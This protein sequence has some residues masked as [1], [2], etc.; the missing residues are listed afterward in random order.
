MMT[1]KTPDIL[2]LCGGRGVRLQPTTNL[3]PKALVP[4]KGTPIVDYVVNYFLDR[5]PEKITMC[6]GYKGE[7][8]RAHVAYTWPNADIEYSDAGDSAS[9]LRRLYQ[10]RTEIGDRCIVAYGDTFVNI[11][12]NLLMETHMSK[13]AEIT[14]VT[15][16][17]KSP[18]GL[19]EVDADLLVTQFREKPLQNFFIGMFVIE[20]RILDGLAPEQLDMDDGFGLVDLFQKTIARQKMSTYEHQGLN[21]TFNTHDERKIAEKEIINFYTIK[22]QKELTQ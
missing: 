14:L 16:R 19:I 18:L 2:V 8:I 7:K 3:V 4:I 17:V 1:D 10:A 5:N 9:M 15:A 21:I 6:I 11:D 20:R 22:D 12:T 13:Q